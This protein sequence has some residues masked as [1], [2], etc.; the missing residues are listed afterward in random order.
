VT[1]EV[2][3]EIV[4]KGNAVQ[5][6]AV[7]VGTN[8]EVSVMG[9]AGASTAALQEAALRKLKYVLTKKTAEESK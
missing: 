5:V 1:D 8:T 2:L 9:P 6:S 7:H 3:F 4:R